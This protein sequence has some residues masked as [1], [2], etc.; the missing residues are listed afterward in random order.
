MVVI[1]SK[2]IAFLMKI[3]EVAVLLHP[4]SASAERVFS[5]Y[6]AMYTDRQELMLQDAKELG[7][8]LRYNEN[9]RKAEEAQLI[10]NVN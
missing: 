3:V 5:L 10:V 8:I 1:T 2:S 6:D 4:N 7:L 9:R